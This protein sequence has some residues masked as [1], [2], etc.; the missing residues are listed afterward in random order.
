MT[1]S[2]TL[3]LLL[4]TTLTP[5]LSAQFYHEPYRPQFH[6]TSETGWLNDPNGLVFYHG[7]YHLFFQRTPGGNTQ[8]GPKAWGHAV[9]TD[10]LHWKQLPDA[11]EPDAHTSIWSGSAV[12]DW[13]NTAGFATGDENTI[14]A[15]YTDAGNPFTQCIT[16]SN[17]RGRTWTKYT[18]N[19][20]L[21]HING[22]NR[23]P[24]MIWFEPAKQWVMALYLDHKN[25]YALFTSPDLKK[26]TQIQTVTLPGSTECPDFFPINLDGD[27]SK[28]IWV[29]TGASGRYMLGSFDGKTF[30]PSTGSLTVEY[31]ANCYAAQTFSDIPGADGRR[32]QIGWMR[33]GKYP[34]MPF[35]QQMTIPCQLTLRTTPD[36]PRMFKYPVKEIG[37]L[38]GSLHDW[39]TEQIT[40]ATDLRVDLTGDL[41]D[42]NVEIMPDPSTTFTMNIRGTPVEYDAAK[43]TLTSGKS[44]PLEPKAGRIKLRIL[45]DRT[46][47]E[48]F[49]NDG[50]VAISR[51]F[52]PKP[53]DQAIT[54]KCEKGACRVLSMK[55]YEMKSVWEK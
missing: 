54:L 8:R 12:V 53:E 18:G 6:F 15:M 10:L 31:G 41:F 40:P 13:N 42:I 33:G 30:T 49:G 22:G 55:V 51:C 50:I 47:I 44:A 35:N 37:S 43:K 39:T 16:Y 32:I 26:W 29:F 5:S 46:S 17:D 34:L 7:E 36:G 3:S 4:L 9:G 38:Y 1:L 23:D 48:V 45:V 25:D 20:V 21:P 52:L 14:V 28:P 11:I 24:K 2:Q 19:P 27:A